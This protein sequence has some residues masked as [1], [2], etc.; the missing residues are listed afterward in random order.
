MRPTKPRETEFGYF[1]DAERRQQGYNGKQLARLA[2]I[3]P[4]YLSALETGEKTPTYKVIRSLAGALDINPNGLLKAAKILVMPL[5]AGL[6]NPEDVITFTIEV[7]ARER[8]QLLNYL[9]FL[10]FR[11]SLG[12]PE[13]ASRE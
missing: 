11:A 9:E 1:L 8:E 4:G 10:R 5:E 7:D 2:G 3:S 13:F 12:D 6:R